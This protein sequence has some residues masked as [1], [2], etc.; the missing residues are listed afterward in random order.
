MKLTA[1]QL[2]KIIR[3]EVESQQINEFLG[4]GK[5]KDATPEK[6]GRGERIQASLE[7]VVKDPNAKKS[8]MAIKK[9]AQALASVGDSFKAAPVRSALRQAFAEVV[10]ST[11]AGKDVTDEDIMSM[12]LNLYD[13]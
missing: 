12:F 13:N 1:T 4:F 9:V 11:E 3:E 6:Q 2:R 10:R 8:A 7:K 5:K